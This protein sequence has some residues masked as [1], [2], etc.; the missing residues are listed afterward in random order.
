[1]QGISD[2]YGTEE[3]VQGIEAGL[4]VPNTIIM[5]P[6]CGHAIHRDQP[7]RLLGAIRDFASGLKGMQN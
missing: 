1:M 6:D 2:A 7:D 4:T 3:Q 5:L